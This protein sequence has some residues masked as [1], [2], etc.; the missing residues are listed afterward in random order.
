MSTKSEILTWMVEE[1]I[2]GSREDVPLSY[3]Q[4]FHGTFH[5]FRCSFDI[6]LDTIQ[7]R[8]LFDNH[9]REIFEQLGQTSDI[10]RYFRELPR[11]FLSLRIDLQSVLRLWIVSVTIGVD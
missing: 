9:S 6:I 1:G 8:A 2:K 7:D 10:L 5:C 3:F 4:F 11:S